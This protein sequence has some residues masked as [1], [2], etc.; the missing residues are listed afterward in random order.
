METL[1]LCNFCKFGARGLG[2]GTVVTNII[3]PLIQNFGT[4]RTTLTSYKYPKT[5]QN[6]LN[7]NLWIFL[8]IYSFCKFGA[9]GLGFG[10]MMTIILLWIRNF[11]KN[12][13]TLTPYKSHKTPKTL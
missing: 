4:I 11:G 3:L 10:T 7:M 5:P 2:F 9:R 8:Q 6:T 1:Q 12:R 13:T